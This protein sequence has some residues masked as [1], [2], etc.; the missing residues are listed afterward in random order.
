MKKYFL[1][2]CL[3]VSAMLAQSQ[4]QPGPN[5]PGQPGAQS[6]TVPGQQQPG[7]PGQINSQPGAPQ[8]GV[9]ATGVIPNDPAGAN[10]VGGIIPGGDTNRI[11]FGGTNID[12]FINDPTAPNSP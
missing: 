9:G 12:R 8:T 7:V 6:G 10:R 4:T 11:P 5:T 2:S 3:A 1:V